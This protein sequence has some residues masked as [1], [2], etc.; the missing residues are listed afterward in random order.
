MQAGD[1]LLFRGDLIHRGGANNSSARRR[2]LSISYSVP[3]VRTVENN[4]LHV[5]PEDAKSLSPQLQALLGFQAYDGQAEQ[6]GMLG[7]YENGNPAA[8]LLD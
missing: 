3:W 4:F 8:V 2:A 7:L 5:T 1:A 6:A